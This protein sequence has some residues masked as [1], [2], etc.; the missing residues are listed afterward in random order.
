MIT[1]FLDGVT[2]RLPRIIASAVN[3]I[4]TFLKQIAKAVPKFVSAGVDIIIGFLDG[5][6]KAIPRLVKKGLEVAR[7]FLNGIADGLSGLADVGFKAIIRFLNGIEKAI[8]ENFD[9]L[10]DAAVGI[11]D[12][13]KDGIIQ[14]F[15][16]AGPLVKKALDV[17]FGF[18]PD[19]VKKLLGIK[20]PSKV[21]IEIGEQVMA[22]FIVGIEGSAGAVKSTMEGA[23]DNA[24]KTAAD[25]FSGIS[26]E[27][28]ADLN[29]VITPVLDLSQVEKDAQGLADLTNVTP[30]TAAA[31]YSQA[32]AISDSQTAAAEDGQAAAGGTTFSYTQN[33]YS[34]ES[35]SDIEIYR[36]TRNQLAQV[37]RGLGLVS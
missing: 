9:D 33:N 12:A 10:I 13:I 27:G 35:L 6:Q 36:Q 18:I 26:L 24:V 3:L 14:A 25:A 11:G 23:A 7:T 8:R 5:V 22:G 21:F 29:P 37:R 31:S 15:E 34:P 28:I 32:A 1:T 4:T 2:E 30:I 19:W 17:L 20:S 16:D